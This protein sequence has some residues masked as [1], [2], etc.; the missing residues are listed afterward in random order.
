M[1]KFHKKRGQLTEK[2]NYILRNRLIT[3]GVNQS[4][5]FLEQAC[6]LWGVL[7]SDTPGCSIAL[8]ID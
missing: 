5:W 4:T 8:L 3:G 7:F 2:L 6:S 1:L